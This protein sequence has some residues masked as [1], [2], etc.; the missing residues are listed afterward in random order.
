V[1]VFGIKGPT[2]EQLNNR[3]TKEH[4]VVGEKINLFTLL[5]QD[6]NEIITGGDDKHLE[7]KVSVARVRESGLDK[8]VFSTTVN[9]HNLFGK[10]YLFFILPFHRLAVR[11]IL[12]NAATAGRI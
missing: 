5:S 12:S 3:I 11:T 2:S 7:F 4:Y 6:E 9:P 8:I 10:V 1:S